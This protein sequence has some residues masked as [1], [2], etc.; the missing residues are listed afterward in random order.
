M[1][2]DYFDSVMR[3]SRLI[4]A[5]L[6]AA[7]TLSSCV[8]KKANA[9][10]SLAESL[11]E[12]APDSTLVVMETIDTTRLA[13]KAQ[14]ARYS[15]LYSMALDKNY[16]DTTDT[17]IIMPAVRYYNHHGSPDMKMK[18]LYYLGRVQ[19]NAGEY[20]SAV[21]SLTK[22]KE[23]FPSADD[24]QSCGLV[25][26]ALADIY[27]DYH[28]PEEQKNSLEEGLE[29]FTSANDER[30]CNLMIGRLALAYH[31]L[32]Q[33]AK[34]DSL[35]K[36]ALD[37]NV[38]DTFA[39]RRF[40]SNYAMMKMI[41]PDPDYDGAIKA[42]SRLAY[43]YGKGLDTQELTCYAFAQELAGNHKI[44][45]DIL[46]LGCKLDEYWRY[47]ILQ[48]RHDYKEA[49]DCLN[50]IYSIQDSVIRVVL[51]NSISG[52][53]KNYYA[54]E[55]SIAHYQVMIGRFWLIIIIL[56]SLVLFSFFA[57]LA[58]RKIKKERNERK[59]MES[60]LEN[61]NAMLNDFNEEMRTSLS[62]L[63]DSFSR[64][65]KEQFSSLK[66]LCTL[67]LSTKT[68]DSRKDR[69]YSEVESI[70]SFLNTD[71]KKWKSFESNVNRRLGN[72]V[73]NLRQEIPGLNEID[74]KLFCYSIIKLDAE[75]IST[76]TGLTT[77]NIYSRKSRLK[78]RIA[79]S[80][81]VHKDEFLLF[82]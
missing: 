79:S 11:M 78:D 74:V 34:A 44:Y 77:S 10:M 12:D 64:L 25:C 63:H 68:M 13:D 22:A 14:R 18:S 30:R 59:Q 39:M 32:H 51:K 3:M 24:N 31:D 45:D 37:K 57:V 61:A 71:N 15:L 72:V 41:Q 50:G 60:L 42:F 33:W 76:I 5:F 17:R 6:L 54:E 55:S 4:I 75:T 65:Y 81:S 43:D 27:G 62:V 19:Y 58:V 26:G 69:I 8:D 70:L 82:F 49:I 1:R 80:N 46:S 28:L 53:L 48:H 40:L 29:Y 73:A 23:L 16:I 38:K 67:Y 56:S 36:V 20:E 52:A 47:R 7:A 35:Y 9:A 2:F 21:V 66:S